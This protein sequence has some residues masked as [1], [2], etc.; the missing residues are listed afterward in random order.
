M[1]KKLRS[2]LSAYSAMA[3]ATMVAS[4]AAG[5]IIYTD[6]NPDQVLS[7]NG[8]SYNIDLNNDLTNDFTITLNIATTFGTQGRT[9]SWTPDI[10]PLNS[11]AVLN[12]ATYPNVLNSGATIGSS[13]TFDTNNTQILGYH[14]FWTSNGRS[15]SATYGPWNNQTDKYIGLRLTVGSNTY[16]GWVRI[17]VANQYKSVTIKDFAYENANGVPIKA[18]GG[19]VGIRKIDGMNLLVNQTSG[20]LN[21]SATQLQ[22]AT[23]K[24]MDMS[25]K[26]HKQQTATSSQLTLSTDGLAKGVY[27]VAVRKEDAVETEKI[28]IQ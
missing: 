15:Y 9:T 26:V 13:G 14:K 4:S 21:I 6:V 25:G 17:S 23:I 22:G 5:T 19:P 11:N 10:T 24:L 20:Q 1:D 18:G 27:L 16:Y 2:K 7:S 12:S 28:I 3:G 8:Q